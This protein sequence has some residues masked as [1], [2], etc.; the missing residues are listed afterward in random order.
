M[1]LTYNH[2]TNIDIKEIMSAPLIYIQRHDTGLY[3]WSVLYGNV[4]ID[5][6]IGDANIQSCL[7]SAMASIPENERLVEISF[8]SIHMGTYRSA[9]V[10][11]NPHDIANRIV[12][13]F[14]ALVHF[15]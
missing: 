6:E 3:E 13:S 4:K 9:A 8:E 2:R 1:A 12:A 15:A 5:G 10:L 7:I 14:A 11:E